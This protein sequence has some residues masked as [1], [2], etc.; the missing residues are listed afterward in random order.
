MQKAALVFVLG[1]LILL[2]VASARAGSICPANAPAESGYCAISPSTIT[3]VSGSPFFAVNRDGRGIAPLLGMEMFSFNATFTGKF[4]GVSSLVEAAG[5]RLPSAPGRQGI[6]SEG[7]GG[8][9]YGMASSIFGSAPDGWF[10]HPSADGWFRYHGSWDSGYSGSSLGNDSSA[11]LDPT[12]EP[13]TLALFGT[14]LLLIAF[15]ARRVGTVRED[16]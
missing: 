2:P 9:A 11:P 7:E 8:G 3:G 5:S 10:R 14:G 15:L 13:F 1:M 6:G 16:T 12:P 4:A